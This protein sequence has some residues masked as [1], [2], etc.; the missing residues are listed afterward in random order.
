MAVVAVEH[1]I[2]EYE[3][4]HAGL[5][6]H[7]RAAGLRRADYVGALAGAHMDDVQLPAGRFAPHHGALDGL[8][9][10]EVGA[11]HRVQP[12]AVLLHQCGGVVPRDQ[13]VE[14]TRRLG[15]HEEHGAVLLHLLERAVHRAVVRLPPLG[16][17][18]HELL[19]GA[20]AAVDHTLD[21]VLVLVPAGDADVKGVVDQRLALGFLV[22]VVGRGGEGVTL[23]RDREVDEG[24]DAAA[25]AGASARLVVVGAHGAHEWECQVHV[26]VEH[27]GD[28]VMPGGVGDRCAGGVESGAECGDLPARDA[29]V[30]GEGAA[31]CYDVA[32]PDH[33]VE[34]HHTLAE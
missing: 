12:G 6:D 10:D 32:A 7:R 2:V 34:S 23:V 11:R 31:R 1:A 5:G 15:V 18:D 8:G 3:V 9:L 19:E 16:L 33:T 30:T 26:H 17:V 20:E 25:R 29:H 13:L 28:H 27:T 14:H 22:P 24:G 4:L 21:L